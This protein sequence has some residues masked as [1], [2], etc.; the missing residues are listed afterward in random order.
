MYNT[1]TRALTHHS[2]D[3]IPEYELDAGFEWAAQ[4]LG[5]GYAVLP[6]PDRLGQTV[7]ERWA[8]DLIDD[9]DTEE[10]WTGEQ[11]PSHIS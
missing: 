2:S 4:L 11:T 1:A 7:V 5:T 8:S 10:Y 6:D 3:G 9:P